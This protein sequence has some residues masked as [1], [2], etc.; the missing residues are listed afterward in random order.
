MNAPGP[1]FAPVND[2]E[3]SLVALQAGQLALPDF[4][5]QL[6]AEPVYLLLDKQFADGAQWDTPGN[7]LVLKNADGL[8][9]MAVF[10]APG[11][12]AD[13]ARRAPLF[14]FGLRVESLRWLL[15]RMQAG[16]GIALNPGWPIALEIAATDVTELMRR[17]GN[18]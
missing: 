8:P 14:G 16:S 15:G 18:A 2:L 1:D 5:D 10:T 3:R 13:W 11:R 6:L 7:P 12:T 17:A 4:L 9:L